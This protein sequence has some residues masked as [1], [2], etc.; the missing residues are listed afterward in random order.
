MQNA[1]GTVHQWT[2]ILDD[3]ESSPL[4]H[5]RSSEKYK[6]SQGNDVNERRYQALRISCLAIQRFLQPQASF[7]RNSQTGT[8]MH[9]NGHRNGLLSCTGAAIKYEL[10]QLQSWLTKA[11]PLFHKS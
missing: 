11:S 8:S 10:E 1:C 7:G 4:V 6:S 2:E 5:Q 3:I 9:P